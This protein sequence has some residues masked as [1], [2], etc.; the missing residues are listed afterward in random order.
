MR[1]LIRE[2]WFDSF[3][4]LLIISYRTYVNGSKIF[5]FSPTYETY[6]NAIIESAR[7]PFRSLLRNLDRPMI[8]FLSSLDMNSP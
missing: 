3:P 7:F 8:A 4:K 2:E 1:D 6:T 5:L